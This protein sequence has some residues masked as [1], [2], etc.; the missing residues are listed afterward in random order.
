MTDITKLSKVELIKSINFYYLKNG[1]RCENLTKFSKNKLINL[2][3]END[4]TY[5]DEET[6]KN[7]IL[8]IETYNYLKDIIYGNFIKYENIP[9]EV[10]KTIK[11]DSNNEELQKII[12]KYD[13]KY[14]EEF[15]TLKEFV[16][17]SYKLYKTFCETNNIKNECVYIT[18]PSLT[19][20]FK[21]L[22]KSP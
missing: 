1:V 6:L 18:L 4:I 22:S 8:T 17:N 21:N 14:E 15:K 5:V 16:F 3:I 20:A 11:L 10:I 12:D 9:Y 13:L 19:N 2:M 7:E